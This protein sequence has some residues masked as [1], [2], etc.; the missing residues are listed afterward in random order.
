MW[1]PDSAFF[2][3]RHAKLQAVP[4]GTMRSIGQRCSESELTD[5]LQARVML[6]LPANVRKP[7]ALG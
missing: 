2:M 3:G 1:K 5:R 4:N 7:F 6:L